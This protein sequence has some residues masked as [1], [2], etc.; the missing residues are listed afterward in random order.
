MTIILMGSAVLTGPTP[1]GASWGLK[2][3]VGAKFLSSGRVW[4]EGRESDPHPNI[5]HFIHIYISVYVF[6]L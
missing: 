4:G 1:N 3:E 5:G 6:S 2:I